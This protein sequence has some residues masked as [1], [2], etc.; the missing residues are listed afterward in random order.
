MKYLMLVVTC[1]IA[2]G[3]SQNTPS[4]LKKLDELNEECSK[5][6][7]PR[8]HTTIKFQFLDLTNSC[9]CIVDQKL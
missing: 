3:C 9:T 5:E 7:A 8:K 6:C 2:T 4:N 1:L